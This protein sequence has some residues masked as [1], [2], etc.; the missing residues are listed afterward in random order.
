M[1]NA[2]CLDQNTPVPIFEYLCSDCGK[3]FQLLIGMTAERDG[4]HCPKCGSTK[5][6]KLV[7]R[8]A[9]VRNEDDRLSEL[10]DRMEIQGEPDSP[11][12]MRRLAREAGAAMDEDMTD[13]MEQM[14]EEDVTEGSP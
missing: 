2:G 1:P 3:K 6:K 12:E 9:R 10:A 13:E 14:L 4:D 8:F 11:A 5:V 7:S